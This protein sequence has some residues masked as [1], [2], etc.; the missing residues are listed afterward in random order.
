[1]TGQ[2]RVEPISLASTAIRAAKEGRVNT[3]YK[4]FTPLSPD[5]VA[6][7]VAYV[8]NAPAHVNILEVIVMP[9]AQRSIT[10]IHRE[11]RA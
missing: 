6:D 4:G 10:V 9:T 3:L 11:E 5:D 1:M 2:C 7:V 8:V